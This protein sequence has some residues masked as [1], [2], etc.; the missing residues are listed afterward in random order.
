MDRVLLDQLLDSPLSPLVE[1]VGQEQDT[2]DGVLEPPLIQDSKGD[3]HGSG[4]VGP[5]GCLDGLDRIEDARLVLLG[6]PLQGHQP[7]GSVV[8]LDDRDPV[9]LAEGIDDEVDRLG[10]ELDLG[11]GHGAGD[12]QHT[13]EIDRRSVLVLLLDIVWDH[14]VLGLQGAEEG[15]RLLATGLGLDELTHGLHGE[16]DVVS[17]TVPLGDLL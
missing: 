6:E 13:D 11:P 2:G 4:D 8:E 10:E 5:T 7:L 16:G 1:A 9:L 17:Q 14:G 3:V 15:H 12:V